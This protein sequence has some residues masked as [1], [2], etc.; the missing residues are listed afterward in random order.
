[1]CLHGAERTYCVTK[2]ENFGS[3]SQKTETNMAVCA[4]ASQPGWSYVGRRR[5]EM[6]VLPVFLV[7]GKVFSWVNLCLSNRW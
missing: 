6:V 7:L 3:V 4:A 1:M 2:D 5:W